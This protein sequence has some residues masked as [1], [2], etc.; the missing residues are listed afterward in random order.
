[1]MKIF[2]E[3]EELYQEY[4]LLPPLDINISNQERLRLWQESVQLSILDF[5]RVVYLISRNVDIIHLTNAGIDLDFDNI[6]PVMN[7]LHRFGYLKFEKNTSYQCSGLPAPVEI[8]ETHNS[9]SVYET[10]DPQYN[11]FPCTIEARLKR[12]DKLIHD[13]PYVSSM[14]V[15]LLGDDDLVSV[16]L[17]TYTPF[18]PVV[19]EKDDCV[20]KHLNRYKQE[21]DIFMEII[22]GD[23]SNHLNEN[24]TFDTFI[25]D[26]PYTLYGI[27]WFLYHGLNFLETRDRV[28]VIANQMMLGRKTLSLLFQLTGQIGLFPVEIIPAFNEYALPSHYREMKDWS[29]ALTTLGGRPIGNMM[30]SASTLYVFQTRY[31]DKSS[32]KPFV[33]QDHSI[34]SR[35]KMALK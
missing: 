21:T 23:L 17:A 32:L 26:P 25:T 2:K 9:P 14:R 15:G 29:T 8:K 31:A 24:I 1:M 10:P 27:L 35:Y 34:Y 12:I 6:A 19:I 18:T 7:V 22:N 11:Q 20:I 13:Y 28:Y 33:D 4:L 5:A 16:D 3:I 30:S